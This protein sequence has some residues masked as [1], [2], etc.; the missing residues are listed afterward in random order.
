MTGYRD[1]FYTAC[2]RNKVGLSLKRY[3]I[4]LVI[5]EG[6]SSDGFM[7]FTVFLLL[8][9]HR[10]CYGVTMILLH[11]YGHSPLSSWLSSGDVGLCDFFAHI[12][13]EIPIR[14]QL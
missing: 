10:N 13:Q 7:V 8:S 5:W 3:S 6:A 14:L 2:V 1:N 12:Q 11:S 9:E 4:H